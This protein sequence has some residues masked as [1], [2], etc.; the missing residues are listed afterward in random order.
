M[1]KTLIVLCLATFAL[2]A[3]MALAWKGVYCCRD[4]KI[5]QAKSTDCEKLGGKILRELPKEGEPTPDIK[6]LIKKCK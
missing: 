4:G 1:K 3:P 6:E 5:S 2:S